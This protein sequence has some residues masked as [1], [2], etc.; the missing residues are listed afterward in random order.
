MIPATYNAHSLVLIP[1]PLIA[2][3]VSCVLLWC[4][5]VFLLTI[6]GHAPRGVWLVHWALDGQIMPATRQE[7]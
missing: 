2:N 1:C 4:T 3:A 6:F 7:N 5:M